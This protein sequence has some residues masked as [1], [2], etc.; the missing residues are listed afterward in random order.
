MSQVNT[1]IREALDEAVLYSNLEYCPSVEDQFQTS[2]HRLGSFEEK[3]DSSFLN[4]F[5][6]PCGYFQL[7]R[8]ASTVGESEKLTFIEAATEYR[9]TDDSVSRLGRV[10]RILEALCGAAVFESNEGASYGGALSQPIAKAAYRVAGATAAAEAGAHDN[11]GGTGPPLDLASY[12]RSVA[13]HFDSARQAGQQHTYNGGANNNHYHGHGGGA[14]AYGGGGVAEGGRQA[15]AAAVGHD[16]RGGGTGSGLEGLLDPAILLRMPMGGERASLS[17]PNHNNTGG[18]ERHSVSTSSSGG[19]SESSEIADAAEITEAI[20]RSK[21]YLNGI[22]CFL[23]EA[24]RSCEIEMRTPDV[25]IAGIRDTMAAQAT[26]T[27]S[28][29]LPR[30][31]FDELIVFVMNLVETELFPRFL[32]SQMYGAYAQMQQYAFSRDALSRAGFK[33]LKPLGRG[34][35]GMVHAAQ[36]IDTGKLYAVKCMDKRMIKARHATRMIVNERDVLASVD[37]PFITGL[38]YAFQDE[39]EVFYVLDLKTG[40]DLEYYLLHLNRPFSEE[41]VRFFAAEILLGIKYLHEHGIMHRR[42]QGGACC[43]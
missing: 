18:G 29:H 12:A 41:E 23:L 19:G 3:L 42:V 11:G 31:I 7:Q 36:K 17:P 24:Y 2:A 35:Y 28:T 6:Q 13:Q 21:Q 34:G 5:N 22:P 15:Y 26:G 43:S 30:N 14:Y 27:L 9:L 16:R 8:F 33:W 25:I 38:Q 37:H 39:A 20:Q 4:V 40:G 1:F 10:K 32:H